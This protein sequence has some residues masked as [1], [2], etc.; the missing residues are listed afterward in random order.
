MENNIN[1][2]KECLYLINSIVRQQKIIC[3][4]YTKIYG[5]DAKETKD[6]KAKLEKYSNAR[7]LYKERIKAKANA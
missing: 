5:K 2:T 1:I 6:A 7:Q 4:I 3:Q